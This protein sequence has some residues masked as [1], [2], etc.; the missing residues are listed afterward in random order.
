[1]ELTSD[2]VFEFQP[3]KTVLPIFGH[4]NSVDTTEVIRFLFFLNSAFLL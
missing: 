4:K 3:M 1:M 2:T